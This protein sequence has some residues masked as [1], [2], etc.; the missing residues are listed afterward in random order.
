MDGMTDNKTVVEF[1]LRLAEVGQ[2]SEYLI[3][4]AIK[5]NREIARLKSLQHPST[6]LCPNPLE[7]KHPERD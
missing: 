3:N 2:E 7:E 4:Q 5:A 1:D 6:V